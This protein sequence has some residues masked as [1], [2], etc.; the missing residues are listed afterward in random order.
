MGM[1]S[2]C[3]AGQCEG[4]YRRPNRCKSRGSCTCICQE[5]IAEKIKGA[6]S[7]LG[8]ALTVGA[9]VVL[10]VAT[11][12]S[13]AVPG[14]ALVGT[15][16][17]M[18]IN[19]ISKAMSGEKMTGKDYA[20]D[21]VVGA[22]TGAVTA[23]IGAGGAAASKGCSGLVKLGARAGAGLASG[24]SSGAISET[25]RAVKGE[26][27]SLESFGES[28]ALGAVCGGLGGASDH[29]AKNIAKFTTN[30][31]G[32]AATR[33]STKVVSKTVVE[34]GKQKIKNPKV[35]FENVVVESGGSNA[36]AAISS[37]VMYCL[38]E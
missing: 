25:G 22:L 32:K 26:E 36:I 13:A 4:K 19:P 30:G 1:C 9:G 37:D 11:G 20:T 5:D 8:G 16:S 33:V 24:V 14:A 18:V 10:T 6:Y 15:G 31:I 38:K 2:A 23:G 17:S 3:Y 35:D 21:L 7:I 34:A 28:M 27:T 12:G 29:G